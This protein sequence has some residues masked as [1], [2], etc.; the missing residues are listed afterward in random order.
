MYKGI[1]SPSKFLDYINNQLPILYCGPENTNAYEV[2]GRFGGGIWVSDQNL[3]W[4]NQILDAA[5]NKSYEQ[6]IQG[7]LKA[8][9]YYQNKNAGGLAMEITKRW[10][11]NE[12]VENANRGLVK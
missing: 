5:Q 12:P 7:T 10:K 1:V 6:L 9:E 11:L 8:M 3:N 2:C 4:K